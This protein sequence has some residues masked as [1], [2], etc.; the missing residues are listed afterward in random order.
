MKNIKMRICSIILICALIVGGTIPTFA[1]TVV[2]N[3]DYQISADELTS[4]QTSGDVAFHNLNN[5]LAA[6]IE[7]TDPQF[8]EVLTSYA[9]SSIDEDGNLVVYMAYSTVGQGETNQI[10]TE[11]EAVGTPSN[12]VQFV[13][14]EYSYEELKAYQNVMWS[15]R[16]HAASDENNPDMSVWA[17]KIYSVAINPM[18][19]RVTVL[20]NDF[21][22]LD[23]AYCDMLFGDYP[24]EIDATVIDNEL[25]EETIELQPGQAINSTGGSIGY[26]CKLNG[27]EGFVTTIHSANFTSGQAVR[28]DGVKIGEIVQ[29]V[30][31]GVADFTFVKMTNTNYEVD[32]GT[33]TNPSYILHDNHYVISMP[34]GCTIYMAG[35]N[36]NTVRVGK[37]V[38]YDY[39]ISNGTSWLIADYASAAGDSG[40][41]V[42][43]G[44]NGDYCVV[45]I[46][47][48]SI[49]VDSDAET[50][51]YITKHTTMKDYFNI[52]I[53]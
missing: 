51:K 7:K 17:N 30:Y 22:S 37:V 53:Y 31:D 21:T 41:C 16:N 18:N 46:H 35:R 20:G 49:N 26:R 27:V 24:Y 50:E 8:S 19:N 42:F 11:L 40:G 34:I 44:V 5:L 4:V 33:N 38:Y 29:S 15:I 52:Y 32:L 10:I 23:Y 14:V 25:I 43:A 39:A 12:A 6:D 9:G 28:I 3:G 45:G 36:S 13:Q 48:G 47:N 1:A 2:G